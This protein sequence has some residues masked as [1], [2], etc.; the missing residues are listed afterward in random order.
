MPELRLKK[1]EVLL[2]V[3][4]KPETVPGPLLKK[5]DD[6]RMVLFQ[7]P[8]ATGTSMNG[9]SMGSSP[10]LPVMLI[11]GA[12]LSWVVPI[13]IPMLGKLIRSVGMVIE[14]TETTRLKSTPMTLM[15][16]LSEGM[17][18]DETVSRPSEPVIGMSR[19]IGTRRFTGIGVSGM[20]SVKLV[21]HRPW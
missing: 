2:P 17:V 10:P 18:N 20:L 8:G 16:T 19:K 6:A 7:N 15:S 5:P 12:P 14:L 9:S 4:P 13:R 21:P 11:S 1:P 3:L